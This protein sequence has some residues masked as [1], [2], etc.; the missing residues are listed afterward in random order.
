[1]QGK[2]ESKTGK[3]EIEAL[4]IGSTNGN[5]IRRRPDTAVTLAEAQHCKPILNWQ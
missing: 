4:K 2:T 3:N 1:L 5:V